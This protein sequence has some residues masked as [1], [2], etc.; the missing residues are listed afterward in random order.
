MDLSVKAV[1]SLLSRARTNLR[2]VL[3]EYIY[4]DGD[5]AAE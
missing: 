3:Q 1:K 4:M 2:Q 5:S